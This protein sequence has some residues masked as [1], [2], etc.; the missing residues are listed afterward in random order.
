MFCLLCCR[1]RKLALKWHPDKNPD[2]KEEAEGNFKLIS[3]AY[4]VL[5]DSKLTS[6]VS[7]P[8][9]WLLLEILNSELPPLSLVCIL[10]TP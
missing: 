10:S 4:D 1:Y 6:L 3:E 8:P 2:N 9:F 5:S 7:N